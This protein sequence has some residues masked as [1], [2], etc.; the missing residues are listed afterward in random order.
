MWRESNLGKAPRRR[1]QDAVCDA[2]T[3]QLPFGKP[4]VDQPLHPI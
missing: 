3:P 2:G 1:V 4:N